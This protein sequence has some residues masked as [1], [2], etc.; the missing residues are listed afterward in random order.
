M[1]TIR[2]AVSAGSETRAEQCD[3]FLGKSLATGGEGPGGLL[4][5]AGAAVGT[6]LVDQ[7]F[8]LPEIRLARNQLA[9]DDLGVLR[10]DLNRHVLHGRILGNPHAVAVGVVRRRPPELSFPGIHIAGP[11]LWSELAEGQRSQFGA[12]FV[13]FQTDLFERNRFEANVL[14]LRPV[15]AVVDVLRQPIQHGGIV[16]QGKVGG[17]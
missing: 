13:L 2:S 8:H 5:R 3:L 1:E 7:R 17:T 12:A 4:C 14:A 11:G 16:A 10:L 15:H 9:R 6:G